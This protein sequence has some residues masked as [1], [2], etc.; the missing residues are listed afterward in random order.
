MLATFLSKLLIEM[1]QHFLRK[2]VPKQTYIAKEEAI[3]PGHTPMKDQVTVLL[4]SCERKLGC[5]SVKSYLEEKLSL[6]ALLILD[7]ATGHDPVLVESV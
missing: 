7:N 2:T 5:P 1:K 3:L 6:T 4:K